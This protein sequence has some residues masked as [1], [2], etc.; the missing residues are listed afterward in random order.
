MSQLVWGR[1]AQDDL[2]ALTRYYEQIDAELPLVLIARIER[3]AASLIEFPQLGAAV[4]DSSARVW[5]VRGTPF[6]I[7]YRPVREGIRI[8]KVA[9][10]STDWKGGR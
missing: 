7:F 10:A 8:L 6:L 1:R 5:L 3:A 4:P 9:H 2:R